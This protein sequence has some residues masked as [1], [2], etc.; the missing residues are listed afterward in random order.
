[1]TTNKKRDLFQTLDKK[2]AP[3]IPVCIFLNIM[4]FVSIKTI[5]SQLLSELNRQFNFNYFWISLKKIEHLSIIDG[6]ISS[7]KSFLKVC[8]E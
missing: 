2:I 5:H 4:M 1:M 3:Q 6:N 8:L 7:I